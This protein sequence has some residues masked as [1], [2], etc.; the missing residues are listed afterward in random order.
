[1]NKMVLSKMIQQTKILTCALVCFVF[2]AGCG[3]G[4]DGSSN[5]DPTGGLSFKLQFID[6]SDETHLRLPDPDGDDVCVAYEIDEIKGTLKRIDG[7]VLASATWPCDAHKGILNDVAP[8]SNL[9][10][11]IEGSVGGEWIW[12]GQKGGIEILSGQITPAGTVNVINV[13]DDHTPPQI[14]STTPSD[15]AAQ[16]PINATIIVQFDEPVEAT[17]LHNAFLLTDDNSNAIDG[18]VSYKDNDDDQLWQAKFD[19]VE[20]LKPQTQYTVTLLD[21]VHDLADN[22]I[23]QVTWRFS[24]GSQELPPL[25]W[26]HEGQQGRCGE[27]VWGQSAQ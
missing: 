5:T 26:G 10:L 11:L 21:V 25:I 12:R 18:V 17:S 20:N 7:T 13:G 2:L 27:A 22:A 14:L 8:T 9:I 23:D 1:M 19:P 16:V 6:P 15:G 3:G 24:T 4:G